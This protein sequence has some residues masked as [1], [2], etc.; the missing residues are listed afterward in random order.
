MSILLPRTDSEII[1]SVVETFVVDVVTD[2][3][4]GDLH[5]FTVHSNL[6]VLFASNCIIST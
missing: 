6:F 3:M 5:N 2:E 1:F 4:F